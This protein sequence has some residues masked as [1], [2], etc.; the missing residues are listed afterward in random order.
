M[1]ARV[2]REEYTAQDAHKGRLHRP[3]FVNCL[4]SEVSSG[5]QERRSSLV[6]QG[7]WLRIPG[8]KLPNRSAT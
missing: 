7:F 1:F 2:E 4:R 5:A 6:A 8:F 3:S